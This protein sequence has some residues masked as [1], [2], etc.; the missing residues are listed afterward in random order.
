[1]VD[2]LNLQKI[3]FP[4]P[5]TI[6]VK[7]LKQRQN[8]AQNRS[9]KRHLEKDDPEKKKHE[10]LPSEDEKK[11]K[12]NQ[13]NVYMEKNRNN[14]KKDNINRATDESQTSTSIDILV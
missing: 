11:N 10:E 6:N 5:S 13:N 7:G 1:M 9:F 2:N 12:D 4:V 8:N 3:L 14:K